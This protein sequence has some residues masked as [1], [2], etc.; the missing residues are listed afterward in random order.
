MGDAYLSVAS[1]LEDQRCL[2]WGPACF[3]RSVEMQLGFRLVLLCSDSEVGC[4]SLE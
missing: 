3:L 1:L 4:P 2:Q